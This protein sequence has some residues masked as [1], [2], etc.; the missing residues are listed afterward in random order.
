[1]F[2]LLATAGLAVVLPG[3][4]AADGRFVVSGGAYFSQIDEDLGVLFNDS[5]SAYTGSVGWRFNEWIS[6]DAGYWDLGEYNSDRFGDGYRIDAKVDTW[7]L[8]AIVGLPIGIVDLYL[9]GGMAF[10]EADAGT[11]EENDEDPFYGFGLGFNLGDDLQIYSEWIR[12]DI[13]ASIDTLGV[14]LRLSF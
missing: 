14:G 13:A 2:L 10:W 11:F 4:A 1:M 5:D 12:F 8:G 3:T 9:R 6:I 7:S